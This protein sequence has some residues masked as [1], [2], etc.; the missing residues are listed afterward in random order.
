MR[1][2]HMSPVKRN[3]EG[4]QSTRHGGESEGSDEP[5]PP[6]T[7][8]G[9]Q[10]ALEETITNLQTAATVMKEVAAEVS[11]IHHDQTQTTP[12]STMDQK[13]VVHVSKCPAAKGY[14]QLK[15]VAGVCTAVI[16]A[17]IGMFLYLAPGAFESAVS[18]GV[19]KVLDRRI[20]E[21]KQYIDQQLIIT[22]YQMFHEHDNKGSAQSFE[23]PWRGAR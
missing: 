4:R 2:G 14:N 7:D 18:K 12:E 23:P 9:K 1:N 21:L 22:Q 16:G 10:R 19:Q 8:T 15:L 13:I 20:P 5:T 6:L 17:F 3:Q 11:E